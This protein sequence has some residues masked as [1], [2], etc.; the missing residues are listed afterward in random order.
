MASH[1]NQGEPL[2]CALRVALTPLPS[3]L[4][5][6]A[7]MRSMLAQLR[8]GEERIN[9]RTLTPTARYKGAHDALLAKLTEQILQTRC[10]ATR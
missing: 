3:E 5:A 7:S 10:A 6:A 2:A 9:A 4:F 8:C 1:P